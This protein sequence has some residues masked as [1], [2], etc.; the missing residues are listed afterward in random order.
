MEKF[1][2]FDLFSALAGALGETPQEAPAAPEKSAPAPEKS[3]VPAQTGVFTAEERRRRAEE[4]ILRHE[5]ISRRIGR[6]R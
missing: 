6:K 4:A 2:L 1:G 5:A 3:A